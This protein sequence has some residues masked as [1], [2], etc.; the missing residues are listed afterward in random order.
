MSQDSPVAIVTHLDGLA[1]SAI[2]LALAHN[3]FEVF[4]PA[5]EEELLMLGAGPNVHGVKFDPTM[6]RTIVTSFEQITRSQQRL[7]VLVNNPNAWSD[8][9]LAEITETMWADVILQNFKAPFYCSRAAASALSASG[10]GRIINVTS[11]AGLSGAHTPYAAACAALISL[12]RSLALE[13]SPDVRV[14]AVATGLL[15]E[16][17]IDDAGPDFRKS[18]ESKVPL[19]R[20]C[21][22][23]DIAE[24]V[25]FLASG[26]DFLTGQIL[27]LRR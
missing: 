8:A 6:E 3:G 11:T 10:E 20:L 22:P 13:L 12:T 18:I 27:E 16:P 15:D 14:N 26:G 19:A 25:T 23:R 17:W 7:D 4:V 24:V 1:G 9:A 21:R 2:V 5:T